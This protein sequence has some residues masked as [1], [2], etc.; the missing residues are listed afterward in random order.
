V[1]DTFNPVNAWLPGSAENFVFS[2]GSDT[3]PAVMLL[4]TNSKDTDG[5]LMSAEHALVM[6][7]RGSND[8]RVDSPRR[9]SMHTEHLHHHVARIR[10]NDG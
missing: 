2:L 3:R 4:K 9:L 1:H 8:L 5:V 10:S 6:G 7:K